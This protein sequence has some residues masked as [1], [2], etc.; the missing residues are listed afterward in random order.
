[1]GSAAIEIWTVSLS[2]YPLPYVARTIRQRGAAEFAPREQKDTRPID[3]R[4]V[5]EINDNPLT[6]FG[7]EERF[8]TPSR[9]TGTTAFIPNM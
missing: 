7:V 2:V 3:D 6:G 9:D 5:F 4:H 8:Q 1:M